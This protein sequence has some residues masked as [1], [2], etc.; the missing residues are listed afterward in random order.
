M[1]APFHAGIVVRDLGLAMEELSQ[2]AGLEW[3]D[4]GTHTIGGWTIHV[5]YSVDGPPHIE[6][7]EGPPGSPWDATDGSRL[8]HLGCGAP[9]DADEAELRR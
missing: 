6:L 1:P 7:I 3:I 9:G 4:L 2:A 5:V 8:D